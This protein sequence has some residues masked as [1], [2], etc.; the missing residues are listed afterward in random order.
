MQTRVAAAAGLMMPLVSEG[1]EK[2]RR[3]ESSAAAAAARHEF[4][5]LYEHSK[6]FDDAPAG[7]PPN[8]DVECTAAVILLYAFPFSPFLCRILLVCTGV[9][10][11]DT[12][13]QNTFS[14]IV[15]YIRIRK[16]GPR[17]LDAPSPSF[18][19]TFKFC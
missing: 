16:G 19:Q 12:N 17:R 1:V 10:I 4:R 11:T 9:S 2:R 5:C 8:N 3:R 13:T 14:S 15:I 6:F 7:C 18:N